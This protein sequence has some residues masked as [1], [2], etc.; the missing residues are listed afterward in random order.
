[1]FQIK[2][3]RIADA[4]GKSEEK[5]STVISWFFPELSEEMYSLNYKDFDLGND[6]AFSQAI[7]TVYDSPELKE[8]FASRGWTVS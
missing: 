1:M 8:V 2:S 5:P 7:I 3:F 6:Q 4:I